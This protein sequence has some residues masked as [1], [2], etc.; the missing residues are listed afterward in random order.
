VRGLPSPHDVVPWL[1]VLRG[2]MLRVRGMG[3]EN[4]NSTV[5]RPQIARLRKSGV[6]LVFYLLRRN[7]E[8]R[9]EQAKTSADANSRG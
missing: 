6:A 4:Q 5:Q 8:A 7:K 9:G 2:A 3:V 1:R